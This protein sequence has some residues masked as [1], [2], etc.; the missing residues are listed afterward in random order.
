M[1]IHYY[2]EAEETIWRQTAIQ[3][4]TDT[5]RKSDLKN[6]P[7]PLDKQFMIFQIVPDGD[8]FIPDAR[9]F[10]MPFLSNVINL[11]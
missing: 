4:L 10:I 7:F 1:F 9:S 11:I 6:L 3:Y 8:G 5:V 2:C